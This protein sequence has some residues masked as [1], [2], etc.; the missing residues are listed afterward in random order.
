VERGCEDG[1]QVERDCEDDT[2]SEAVRMDDRW[3]EA[4]RMTDDHVAEQSQHD[5]QPHRRRVRGDDEIVVHE[6]EHD[7]TQPADAHNTPPAYHVVFFS[8]EYN[9]VTNEKK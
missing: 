8:P 9:S 4:V 6:H 7:P 5:R 2:W 1:W 3:S